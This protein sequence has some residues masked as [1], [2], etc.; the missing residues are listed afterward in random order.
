MSARM[1]H[2]DFLEPGERKALYLLQQKNLPLERM[3]H[4]DARRLLSTILQGFLEEGEKARLF[5]R[6]LAGAFI[7]E[8]IRKNGRYYNRKNF[9]KCW[10][11]LIVDKTDDHSALDPIFGLEGEKEEDAILQT[12]AR[13]WYHFRWHAWQPQGMVARTVMQR[14]KREK[15]QIVDFPKEIQLA[16]MQTGRKFKEG[17]VVRL[18]DEEGNIVEVIPVPVSE[19]VSKKVEVASLPAAEGVNKNLLSPPEKKE[20]LHIKVKEKVKMFKKD[21]E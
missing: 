19:N 9:E 14:E 4:Q 3:A 1:L 2:R 11:F 5:R 6:Y 8:F 10:K 17:E 13:Y 18:K 21:E 15:S 16:L 12:A 7:F 20:F